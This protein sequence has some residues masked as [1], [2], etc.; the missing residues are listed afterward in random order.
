MSAAFASLAQA[1]ARL[2]KAVDDGVNKRG[3]YSLQRKVLALLEYC[4][5]KKEENESLEL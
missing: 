4:I 3:N 1:R 5:F 2:E